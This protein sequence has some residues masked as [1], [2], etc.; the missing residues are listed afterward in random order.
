MT[1]CTKILKEHEVIKQENDDSPRL[2]SY[3]K[4]NGLWNW[5]LAIALRICLSLS[6]SLV[7]LVQ[8]PIVFVVLCESAFRLF[9]G[10]EYLFK[11]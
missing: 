3:F 9:L 6:L 1:N 2:K 11:L 4:D 5:N 7:C 8:I 10:F